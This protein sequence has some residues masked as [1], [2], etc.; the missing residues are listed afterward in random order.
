MVYGHRRDVIGYAKALNEFD[1]QL[2]LMMNKMTNEDLLI[3]TADHGCDPA[4][5]GTDHTREDIPLLI[6]NC[7]EF[8]RN[9]GNY[10]THF[11]FTNVADI[12]AE[13][14]DVDYQVERTV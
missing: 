4:F 13:I 14:F 8:V 12:I 1:V 10:G 7:R 3:I 5:E 11:S 2:G 6:Y 9:R